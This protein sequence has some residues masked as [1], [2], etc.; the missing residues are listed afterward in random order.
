[1]ANKKRKT[2]SLDGYDMAYGGGNNFNTNSANDGTYGAPSSSQSYDDGDGNYAPSS[3]RSRKDKKNKTKRR[4]KSGNI[5]GKLITVV[6]IIALIVGILAGVG[7]IIGPTR[8]QCKDTIETAE[9]AITTMDVNEFCDVIEP[10][11]GRKLRAL[12]MVANVVT[13]GDAANYISSTIE[14][15]GGSILPDGMDVEDVLDQIEIEPYK[16]GLPGKVRKVKC[17]LNVSGSTYAKVE[18]SLKKFEGEVYI[19]KIKSVKD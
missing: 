18:I 4:K 12:I 17:R 8:G 15:L 2:S 10:V 1:M 19:T 9:H 7:A 11:M 6:V 13:P 5:V 14:Q 16:F 3:K